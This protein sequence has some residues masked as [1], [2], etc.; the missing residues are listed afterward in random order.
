M[1]AIIKK[2]KNIGGYIFIIFFYQITKETIYFKYFLNI[3]FSWFI[4]MV[5][6]YQ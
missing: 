6:M 1:D 2:Q 3:F 4:S 5:W